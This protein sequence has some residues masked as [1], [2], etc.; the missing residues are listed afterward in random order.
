MGV[1]IEPPAPWLPGEAEFPTRRGLFLVW[2]PECHRSA[3]T[4]R[5]FNLSICYIWPLADRSRWHKLARYLLSI[6]LTV[7]TLL[8]LRPD[9]LICL[10]QPPFLVALVAVY[11]RLT[12]VPYVLDSHS[13]AFGKAQWR[14]FVPLYRRL[15]R[16]ALFNINHNPNERDLVREWGARSWLIAEI[17]GEMEATR[18]APP[19]DP[20][21]VVYVCSFAADEPL[22]AV[23]DAARLCPDLTFRVTGNYRKAPESLIAARPENVHFAGFLE[24]EDYL[25]LLRGSGAVLTL[26]DRPHIMQMAAEE[27]LCLA[28]PIVTN[29]SPVLEDSF[30]RGARFVRIEAG[31]IAAALTTVS[32]E[33]AHYRCEIAAQREHRRTHLRALLEEIASFYKAGA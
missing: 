4:A 3:M 1:R 28:V 5:C 32:R 25:D 11:G 2:K 33:N 14:W 13:G 10:N 31:E 17:P 29:H 9:F 19:V 30:A 21:Q 22:E 20:R 12:G 16:G 24:R 15:A 27:A 23:F 8:R 18:P 6:G 26:S 7:W